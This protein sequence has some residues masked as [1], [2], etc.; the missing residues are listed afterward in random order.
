[1]LGDIY[2]GIEGFVKAI[3]KWVI[4]NLYCVHIYEEE[5]ITYVSGWVS[6]KHVTCS[7]CGKRKRVFLAITPSDAELREFKNIN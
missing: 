4:Q 3:I 2:L 6:E 7:K 1:M 5:E